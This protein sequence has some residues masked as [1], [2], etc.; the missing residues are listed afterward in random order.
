MGLQRRYYL[1]DSECYIFASI[2]LYYI[3]FIIYVL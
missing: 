2:D 3:R 1:L